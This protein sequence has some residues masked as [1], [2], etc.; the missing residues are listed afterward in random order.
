MSLIY[1]CVIFLCTAETKL[2]FQRNGELQANEFEKYTNELILKS[3]IS[4]IVFIDSH[5][6]E[7]TDI[8]FFF[9]EMAVDYV[10]I[11][12]NERS[13]N[14][15]KIL[16]TSA[17][18]YVFVFIRKVENFQAT[19]ASLSLHLFWNNRSP[20]QFIVCEPLDDWSF[21]S[22][23]VQAIWR[24]DIFNFV[25]VF[26]TDKLYVRSYNLFSPQRFLELTNLPK[27]H[28]NLFPN[29]LRDV[30]GFKLRI[31]VYEIPR[32]GEELRKI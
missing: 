1:F 12:D 20:V 3:Q 21:S 5:L 23:M 32:S 8:A 11:I 31:G 4:E 24:E 15:A 16:H 25:L 7:C 19:L 28:T 13:K 29:K 27:N 18:E 17:H 2:T 30:N 14:D 9:F 10:K 6:K 26:R 22:F